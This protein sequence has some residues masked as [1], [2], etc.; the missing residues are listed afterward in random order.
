MGASPA[1]M[2]DFTWNGMDVNNN[3]MPAGLYKISS[4]A[5]IKG[6]SIPVATA[7]IYNVNSVALDKQGKGVI[8][9]LDGVGGVNMDDVIKII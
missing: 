2:L 3:Q 1:G 4:T 9:N 5:V 6:E 8:L 7:G